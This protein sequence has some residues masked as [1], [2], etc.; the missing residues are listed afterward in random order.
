[1]CTIAYFGDGG[2]SSNDFH[3]AMRFAALFKT[4]TV[5]FC[6]KNEYDYLHDLRP[7]FT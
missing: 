5:L 7:I 1:M 6:R 4:P 2:T 3:S